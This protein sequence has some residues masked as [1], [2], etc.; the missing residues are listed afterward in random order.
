MGEIRYSVSCRSCSGS[1]RRARMAPWM[2]GCRV[3]TRPSSISG[4]PG[5]SATSVTVS[6]ALR[7]CSAVFPVEISS[8]PCSRSPLANSASPVL[9]ETV[10]R[11]RRMRMSSFSILCPLTPLTPLRVHISPPLSRGPIRLT[12]PTGNVSSPDPKPTLGVELDR[13]RIDL[14]FVRKDPGGQGLLGIVVKDRD[15]GLDDDGAGVYPFIGE[16]DGAAG[17]L[18]T[19]S[20]GLAL[21][22][23]PR[24][25]GK[26]GR[27]DVHDP[28][29]K[30]VDKA[31]RQAAMI[32]VQSV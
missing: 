20:Q 4:R 6:P 2:A 16:V 17:K 1:E 11:A 24:E 31:G 23:K 10:K 28:L 3:F 21:G 15:D 5:T 7:R 8:A 12:S 25:R 29:V 27:M 32:T 19:V 9:S 14:M 18:H 13:P 30:K 26:Q 22:V